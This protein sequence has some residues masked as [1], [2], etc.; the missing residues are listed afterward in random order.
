MP[1]KI[2]HALSPKRTQPKRKVS[3]AKAAAS[4][5][6]V[7]TAH[8]PAESAPSGES[9][10][11]VWIPTKTA[12][13]AAPSYRRSARSAARPSCKTSPTCGRTALPIACT[14]CPRAGQYRLATLIERHG[15]DFPGAELLRLVSADCPHRQ[16]PRTQLH[17]LC[18]VYSLG[19]AAVM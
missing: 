4:S 1:T 11:S 5:P 6:G 16:I 12:S 18:D 10:S 8:W 14:R 19:L 17:E 13:D 7:V 9:S 2:V 3:A 15:A